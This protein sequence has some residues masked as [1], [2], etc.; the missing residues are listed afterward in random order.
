MHVR[1]LQLVS[2]AASKAMRAGEGE[3]RKRYRAVCCAGRALA[4]CD[5]ELLNGLSEFV[6]HQNTPVRVLHRRAPLLRDRVRGLQQDVRNSKV[7]IP[8]LPGVLACL[9]SV[10]TGANDF[11]SA[12]MSASILSSAQDLHAYIYIHGHLSQSQCVCSN[13]SCVHALARCVCPTAYLAAAKRLSVS[14]VT[15]VHVRNACCLSAIAYA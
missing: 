11:N 14:V 12:S 15:S 9:R 2:E 6:I 1:Q 4:S 5:E 7:C 13:A 10:Q 3:K 8:L